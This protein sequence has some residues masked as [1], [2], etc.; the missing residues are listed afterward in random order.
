MANSKLQQ[1]RASRRL[2]EIR[3]RKAR[4]KAANEQYVQIKSELMSTEV[5]HDM[6]R[7][8]AFHDGNESLAYSRLRNARK[9]MWTMIRNMD[10]LAK[11]GTK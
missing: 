3:R 7:K 4:R 8:S 11:R 5:V 6:I 1:K 9:R 10:N 2:N